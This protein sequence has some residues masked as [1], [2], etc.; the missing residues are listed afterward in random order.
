MQCTGFQTYPL[1]GFESINAGNNEGGSFD[2]ACMCC[3]RWW[4]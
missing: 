1:P 4:H 2:V 3:E